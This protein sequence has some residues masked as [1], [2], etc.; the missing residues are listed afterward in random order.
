MEVSISPKVLEL[1]PD[2]AIAVIC[3]QIETPSPHLADKVANFKE[4]ALTHLKLQL[5]SIEALNQHPH[6]LAWHEAYRKFG[7]KPKDHRPTH[8]A[9]CRRLLK[10]G[11][12]PKI[13]PLVDIYLT[14]QTTHLLPHGGYDLG[15]ISGNILLDVARQ[16]ERF[17]PMGGGEETVN[18]AEIIYRDNERV[19]TRYWNYRDCYPTRITD[20]TQSF[21]LFIES[22]GKPIAL[23]DLKAAARDLIGRYQES[24]GGRYGLTFFDASM[25]SSHLGELQ[26]V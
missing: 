2:L 13:N 10:Q 16:P 25:S 17:E 18:V 6:I 26:S 20:D 15:Q 21:V 24:F 19:L 12:W 5:D 22:P 7:V 23:E 3:G 4:R 8:D 11:V 9:L 14:N 1:F